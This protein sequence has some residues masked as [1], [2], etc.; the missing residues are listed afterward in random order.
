MNVL[1]CGSRSYSD[2]TK[3]FDILDSLAG[4]LG[5]SKILYRSNGRP[6]EIAC[7]WADRR[8]VPARSI[9]AS[10]V[11]NG[12]AGAVSRAKRKRDSQKP[13]LIVA[14]P[15]EDDLVRQAKSVGLTVIEVDRD[16][17]PSQPSQR[18]IVAASIGSCRKHP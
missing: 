5:I 8:N 2:E 4:R 13:D 17:V 10:W 12:K 7:E 18:P 3:V 16:P 9:E 14:F 6:D 11:S 15:G 1:I